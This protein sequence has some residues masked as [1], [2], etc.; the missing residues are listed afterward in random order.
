MFILPNMKSH[1]HALNKRIGVE[2]RSRRKAMK[3]SQEKLAEEADI[4]PKYLSEIERGSANPSIT[5]FFKIASALKVTPNDL[6]ETGKSAE[7]KHDPRILSEKLFEL[8]KGKPKLQ[9]EFIKRLVN[10]VARHTR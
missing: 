1:D 10:E 4:N 9:I 6:F 8:L 2:I 3:W 5:I 7:N